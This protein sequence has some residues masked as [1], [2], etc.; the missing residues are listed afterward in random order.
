MARGKAARESRWGGRRSEERQSDTKER[1][2]RP[3]ASQGETTSGLTRAPPSNL[4]GEMN[5]NG[6]AAEPL[7]AAIG[8]EWRQAP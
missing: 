8:E 4:A 6:A 5:L 3:T 7:T 1:A 2:W